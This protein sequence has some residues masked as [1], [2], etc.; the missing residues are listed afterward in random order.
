MLDHIKIIIMLLITSFIMLFTVDT[1]SYDKTHNCEKHPIYCQ[2]LK[3]KP[4]MS[5]QYAMRMSNYIYRYSR[6]YKQ[7]PT[8]SIAVGMQETGLKQIH[9]KQNIIIFDENDN[10]KVVKGYTDLCMFQFHIDTIIHHKL[11]PVRLKNDVEYCIEQHFILMRQ[12]RKICSHLG[13]DSWVCYHSVNKV[14]R[15]YYKMLVKEHL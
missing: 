15:E 4:K 9:R 8:I 11:D 1:F 7:D 14:P 10:W 12:K 3:K 2:I 6:I 5:T 13:E